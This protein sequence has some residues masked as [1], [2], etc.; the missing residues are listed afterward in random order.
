MYIFLYIHLI[1]ILLHIMYDLF[2]H[3]FKIIH[4]FPKMWRNVRWKNFSGFDNWVKW[5]V[6]F[7]VWSLYAGLLFLPLLLVFLSFLMY[8]FFYGTSFFLLKKKKKPIYFVFG[9]YVTLLLDMFFWVL[10]VSYYS[11]KNLKT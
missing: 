10:R 3:N 6:N 4:F 5:H 11:T 1:F 2:I 8:P 9:S 7:N